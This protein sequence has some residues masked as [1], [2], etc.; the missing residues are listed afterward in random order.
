MQPAAFPHTCRPAC[1]ASKSTISPCQA[2]HAC[3]WIPCLAPPHP[4]CHRHACTPLLKTLQHVPNL[5][6]W[7]DACSPGSM[8]T[9]KADSL[10][11]LFHTPSSIAPTFPSLLYVPLQLS[12]RGLGATPATLF[13]CHVLH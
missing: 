11:T 3:V 2:Q 8:Q 7:F 13:T 10:N 1:S 12:G 4:A 9:S 5:L 6:A